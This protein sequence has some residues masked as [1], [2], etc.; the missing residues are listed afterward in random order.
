MAPEIITSSQ[1]EYT[2]ASDIYAVGIIYWELFEH[3]PKPF[4]DAHGSYPM[5]LLPLLREISTGLRPEFKRI[6]NTVLQNLISSLWHTN[7]EQRPSDLIS[8]SDTIKKLDVI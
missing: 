1:P 3:N 5:D 6:K 8:V 7:Q 2:E 4:T